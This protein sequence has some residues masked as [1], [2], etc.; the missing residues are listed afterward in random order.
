MH[1]IPPSATEV[2]RFPLA[3]LAI[4]VVVCV[5]CA[6][7]GILCF[8]KREARRLSYFFLAAALIAGGLF[9]PAMFGD[10]I[11]V[12]PQEIATTTGF[13]F[14]PTREGFV[15]QD[16]L[17]VRVTTYYDLKNRACPAELSAGATPSE[18]P[19]STTVGTPMRGLAAS[20]SSLGSRLGSPGA[21]PKRWR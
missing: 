19:C 1:E 3:I 13:W 8:R 11:V 12:S 2:F 5:V 6:I 4:P 16:V 7:L 14:A 17:R 10:R 15:Y 21:Q 20:R 18:P 9:A